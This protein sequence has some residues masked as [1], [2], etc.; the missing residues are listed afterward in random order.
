MRWARWAE[1]NAHLGYLAAHGRPIA[2]I[3]AFCH[4]QASNDANL[5]ASA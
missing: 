1:V 4:A 5:R 2:Q 3:S